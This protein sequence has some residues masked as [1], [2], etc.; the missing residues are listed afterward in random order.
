[1]RGNSDMRVGYVLYETEKEICGINRL[2]KGC[3]SE[4][5]KNTLL[6]LNILGYDYLNIERCRQFPT[7][8]RNMDIPNKYNEIKVLAEILRLELV[9]SFYSPLPKLANTKTIITIHDLAALV[10]IDW[11]SNEKN[12]MRFYGRYLKEGAVNAD[13]IL[14]DSEHTKSDI[15]KYYAIDPE[16]IKVVYPGLYSAKYIT[17]VKNKNEV[18]QKYKIDKEYILSICTVEPRKNLIS[19]IR[20]YEILRDKRPG[21]DLKLVLTGRRGWKNTEIYEIS[22]Q[23]KYASDIVFTD[24]IEDYE[25]DI[26][27]KNTLLFVYISY[28]E[29]FGLPILEAM[30]KGTV[31]LSS[32]TSSMPEVGGDAV[33]YCDPYDMD[34]IVEQMDCLLYD[35]NLR[36]EMKDKALLQADYFSYR[37]MSEETVKIYEELIDA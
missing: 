3:I 9:H 35:E 4:I 37:K 5:Q 24:Y 12:T 19:L 26:L 10:N 21:Y 18:L 6:D 28:Y 23:S 33:C 15:V 1:M 2:I 11:F 25:L 14:A 7:L 34:S 22:A 17:T 30:S 13:C 32:I 27:Y 29:G 36:N 8:Y 31:V 20:A 16:K